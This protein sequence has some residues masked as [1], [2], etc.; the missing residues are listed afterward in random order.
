MQ[1]RVLRS[2]V[3]LGMSVVA[4]GLVASGGRAAASPEV[5]DV[6]AAGAAPPG[7][8]RIGS[9][10]SG[11]DISGS[12]VLSPSDPA[13]LQ[14]FVQAVSDP[15]SSMYRQF[16]PAHAFG[17]RFGATPSTISAV[18]AWLSGAGLRVGAADEDNL[19]IPFEGQATLVASTFGIDLGLYRLGSTT[20]IAASGTPL[21]PQSFAHTVTGLVGLDGLVRSQD[22]LAEAPAA[23]PTSGQIGARP[24]LAHSS[25]A[26]PVACSGAQS[27]GST[28]GA[29][30]AGQLASAYGA[31]N[32]YSQ[33][34]LGA[35][36]TVALFEQEPY[37][38]S[39]INAYEACY[40]ITASVTNEAVDG[41][42]GSGAGQGEAALDIEQLLG[43]APDAS[44]R[45]YE[46][47]N[48]DSAT[49]DIYRTIA[50]DDLAQVVSTSWGLCEQ[51][52]TRSLAVAENGIFEQ[53]AAQGQTM[54]AATGDSGSED[55]YDT[56]GSALLS[57]DD[58][59][60]QPFVTAAGGTSLSSISPPIQSVWNDGP[61]AGGGGISENWS[62]PTWQTGPGVV[63]TYSSPAPCGA[64]SGDCRETPDLSL[65]A[66]PDH[67]D[68]IFYNGG[69][70]AL[71]GTS[72]SVVI[73]SAF[74]ALMDQGCF[75]PGASPGHV[76]GF[77][78]PALYGLSGSAST[79]ITSGENDYTGSHGGLY[80]ATTHF[81][82]AS[83]WGSPVLGTLTTDVQPAGG[84]PSITGLSTS[85]APDSGGTTVV[86][87]GSDLQGVTAVDFGGAPAQ[88]F[89]FDSSNGTIVADPPVCRGAGPAPVSVTTAAGTSATD[90][91]TSFTIVSSGGA[92]TQ[93]AQ[94]DR[95]VTTQPDG[96]PTLFVRGANGSLLNY[97]YV[98]GVWYSSTVE[99]SGVV[100][101]PV[102]V[103]QPDGQP[104]VFFEGPAGTLVNDWYDNGTWNSA[105]IASEG[106]EST[107]SVILQPDGAPSV[108]VRAG[109]DALLNFWYIASTGSWGAATVAPPGSTFSSP[110]IIT[111]EAADD[112]PSVFTLGSGNSLMNYWYIPSTG[113]WGAATVAAGGSA[114]SDPGI[115]AQDSGAPSVLVQGPSNSLLNFWYI[116]S[117]G[118]WGAATAAGS[119]ST[120]SQPAL[121]TQPASPGAPS[122]FV[123]GPGGSL[124]NFWYI[125]SQGNWGAGTVAAANSVLGG[126]GAT[127][128]PDG[129]PSLF[130]VGQGGSLWNYWYA[131]GSWLQSEIATGGVS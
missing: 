62:M 6:Q 87:S 71:G 23:G 116:P 54:S 120:F 92:C 131:G 95:Y 123:T 97:W 88:S 125:A 27:E 80:P 96:S 128:Q 55:C 2:L 16:L 63:N 52:M 118:M 124:L 68:V 31:S 34:R 44:I 84:C 20:G 10:P 119:G 100:S 70:E 69:W 39:D 5:R 107:P 117:T 127:L 126:T 25:P 61:G 89:S 75:T 91:Y 98:N 30:T 79:D 106:V 26:G 60:S 18:G 21:V 17:R 59:S 74:V 58:P 76:M 111:Q 41:G 7:A 113:T 102:V 115:L 33:G 13:A 9:V 103:A 4:T 78:N 56:N 112:A 50:D 67:G 122:A 36:V 46:G 72:A 90:V 73:W 99:A 110:A 24:A 15:Q 86:I 35:G 3:A 94:S 109:G 105:T 81:D 93:T 40:G 38:P 11:T 8:V 37:L 14:D 57:V 77:A 83:G 47:P 65:S 82:L 28:S 85:A 104:S 22:H 45:V 129:S 53:M 48:T 49:A 42:A 19:S 29:Y 32:L 101:N 12:V 51:L 43:L 130:V 64:T 1:R 108:F 66:D 114:Y 121:T